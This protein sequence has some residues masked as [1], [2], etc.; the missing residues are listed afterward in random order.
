MSRARLAS[1]VQVGALVRLCNQAG[2]FAAVLHKGDETAGA[3]LILT[4]ENAAITGLWEHV[5][6]PDGRY[7]WQRTG[8]QDDGDSGAYDTYI[9]SRRHRDPDLWVIELDIANAARFIAEW[10]GDA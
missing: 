8:P 4:R 9:L 10:T 3:L 7:G 6:G 1:A 2:G 5:L